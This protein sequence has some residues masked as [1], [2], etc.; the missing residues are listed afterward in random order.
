MPAV[1]FIG[2]FIECTNSFRYLGIHFDGR[3]LMCETHVESM[4]L[5]FRK[6]LSEVKAMAA[7]GIEQRHLFLLYWCMIAPLTMV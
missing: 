1:S 4:K 5:K 6:G 7:K 3:M 2:D